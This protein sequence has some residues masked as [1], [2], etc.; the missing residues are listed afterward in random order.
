MARRIAVLNVV[1]LSPDMIGPHTPHLAALAAGGHMAPLEPPLPAVT[2]S[3]QSSMLTGL[4]VRDHCVVANGWF[5]RDLD[6]I[7]FWKQANTI[8]QGEKLWEAARRID[9]SATTASMFWWFNMDSTADIAVTPRPQ[10]LSGGRKLP[11]IWT[12]PPHLRQSLQEEFGTFPLFKFWGPGADITSSRWIAEASM[13]VEQLYEPAILLVY[14]PHLDYPLQRVGPSHESIP[15]ELKAI[16]EV[17]GQLAAHCSERGMEVLVLSEYAIDAVSDAVPINLALRNAGLLAVRNEEGGEHLDTAQSRAF[18][19]VDHQ[20]AHVYVRDSGV[21]AEVAA[22]LDGTPGIDLVLHGDELREYALDTGRSGDIVAVA[23]A[24]RWFCHDWW[25]TPDAAP[26]YQRTV[27]IHRKPGYDPRELLLARGWRGSRL[28]TAAK[29]LAR[30][31]G[32]NTPLDVISMDPSRVRGSHGRTPAM[33]A[34]SPL[35]IAPPC[36]EDLPAVIP[37]SGVQELILRVLRG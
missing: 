23:N 11:D 26:D 18:A 6:E 21:V 22:V 25:R 29:L 20:V 2:C 30:S 37:A 9:P 32:I 17:T 34:A 12:N 15:G 35:I 16:D 3:V 8:V 24:D 14:L 27:D 36:I 13:R 4:P 7:R 1:G 5:E 28:R 19:V 10:Y 33:G 31:V